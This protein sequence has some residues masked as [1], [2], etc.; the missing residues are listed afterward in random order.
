MEKF[1]ARKLPRDAQDEMRRQT[2][3]MREEL[4][5]F[6]KAIAKV[7]GVHVSTVI[8]WSKRYSMEGSKGLKSEGAWS[9][10]FVGADADF[11]SGMA[12]ALDHRG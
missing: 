11:G 4:K 9:P 8:G 12:I 10:L 1:D 5:L 7:V 2:M 6:W 3:R